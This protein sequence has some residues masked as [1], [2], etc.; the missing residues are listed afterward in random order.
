MVAV[1]AWTTLGCAPSTSSLLDPTVKVSAAVFEREA[2]DLGNTLDS[3]VKAFAEAVPAGRADLEA[4]AARNQQ[5]IEL[6]GG[7]VTSATTGT[8]TPTSIINT[9]VTAGSIA[10][11]GVYAKRAKGKKKGKA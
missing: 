1:V 10:A 9:L 7:A 3:K 5:L 6:V 4:Q 8:F 2:I 11:V